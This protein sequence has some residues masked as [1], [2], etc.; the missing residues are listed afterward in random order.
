MVLVPI[1]LMS[2]NQ[3]GHPLFYLQERAR[4]VIWRIMYWLAFALTW[5]VLPVLQ[6]YV[7][8]GYHEPSKK[9]FDSLRKNARYQLTI[10]GAGVL[11][12]IYVIL[13]YGLSPLSLKS[14]VIALSHSY[15]L[16]IAVWLLGHGLVNVPRN[17]WNE[18]D[19]RDLLNHRYKHAPKSADAFAEAQS[20]YADVVAEVKAL[21]PYKNGQFVEWIDELLD[22]VE[23]SAHQ[24][25][26][27][28]VSRVT[29]DRSMI[30]EDY[31]VTLSNRVYK[32]KN[33][34]IRAEADWQK[35]IK[36]CSVAE[37]VIN[38]RSEGSLVFRFSRTRLPPKMAFWYYSVVHTNLVRLWAIVCCILAI[39]V[40]WS[41]ITH[42]TVVS[43]VNLVISNVRGF[44]QQMLSTTILGFMCMCAFASLTRIRVFN[45][46]ALVHRSTDISSMVFYA[47]YACRLTVPLSYNYL[48]LITDRDSVFEEFLGKSINL[49]PL[50]KYFNDWLPRLILVP[51]VFTLFHFYDKIK[52]F[53]GYGLAFDDEEQ[54]EAGS[55][56]EGKEIVNRALTDPRSRYAIKT[57]HLVSNFDQEAGVSSSS[58]STVRQSSQPVPRY[59]D[60]IDLESQQ[61]Y[62]SDNEQ[63]NPFRS[64]FGN[65]Q[66]KLQQGYHTLQNHT[67]NRN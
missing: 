53:L 40:V 34:A 4:Y 1:D 51:I 39:S 9:F 7:E 65:I 2:T 27:T 6:S 63:E 42:G 16:V 43:L 14:L 30:T 29:V 22:E 58:S 66:N 28:G 32:T 57:P 59:S 60:R 45:V 50:G 25:T 23:N 31:L 15:A 8:S 12:L 38:S 24:N 33:R 54:D 18:A 3:A 48:T 56:I 13:S 20:S 11:G 67:V 46:Y 21:A 19:P 41:E 47:M 17:L 37:D 44:T 61:P 36:D 26:R 5:A 52:N 55:P 35:L 10:L 64:F 62:E 49:T